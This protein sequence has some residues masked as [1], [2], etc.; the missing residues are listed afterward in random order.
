[1]IELMLK[2][3]QVGT[4]TSKCDKEISQY[5]S[6]VSSRIPVQALNSF[7]KLKTGKVTAKP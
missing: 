3:D 1:M 7:N 6:K 4:I 5:L 2:K